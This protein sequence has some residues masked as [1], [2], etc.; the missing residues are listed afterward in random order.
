MSIACRGIILIIPHLRSSWGTAFAAGLR[1]RPFHSYV[2]CLEDALNNRSAD[3]F[4]LSHHFLAGGQDAAVGIVFR[5]AFLAGKGLTRGHFVQINGD[6]SFENVRC[7]SLKQNAI[8]FPSFPDGL[9]FDKAT[10]VKY[11]N[12]GSEWYVTR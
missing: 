7:I 2:A 1:G 4:Q 9:R 6:R 5:L 12:P 10:A 11:R 8:P 3:G